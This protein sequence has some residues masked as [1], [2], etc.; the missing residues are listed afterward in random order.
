MLTMLKD[1]PGP[2]Y[3]QEILPSAEYPFKKG[4][5]SRLVWCASATFLRRSPLNIH[6]HFLRG[7]QA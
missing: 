3:Y 4:T 2:G 5:W 1:L 7:R 6:Q